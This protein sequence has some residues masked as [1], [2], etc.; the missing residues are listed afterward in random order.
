M[1]TNFHI[2]TIE[3]KAFVSQEELNN[4]KHVQI[5]CDLNM[6]KATLS[7]DAQFLKVEFMLA[8]NYFAPSIGQIRFEGTVVYSGGNPQEMREI[9]KA[10]DS[11]AP[12]ANV[13]NELS[14]VCMQNTAP[15]ALLLSRVAGLPPA[16]PIP[17]INIAEAQADK[18]EES[19]IYQ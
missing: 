14:N 1:I 17:L 18:K 19:T 12:P 13:W 7:S 11:D 16:I 9:K 2:K 6:K 4:Y 3:A 8:L 10:W 5:N 15:I